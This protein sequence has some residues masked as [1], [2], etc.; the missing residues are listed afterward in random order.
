MQSKINDVQA[1]RNFKLTQKQYAW[2]AKP[3]KS[4]DKVAITRA[5]YGVDSMAAHLAAKGLFL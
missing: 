2:K 5:R 3:V 4:L 1:K